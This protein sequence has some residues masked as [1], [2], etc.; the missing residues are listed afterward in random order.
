VIPSLR[1]QFLTIVS[2]FIVIGFAVS[3]VLTPPD[4]AQ[5]RTALVVSGIPLSYWLVC[6]RGLPVRVV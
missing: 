5:I 4:P 2:L 3:A 1:S 6:R